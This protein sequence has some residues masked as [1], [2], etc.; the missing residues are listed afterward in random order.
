LPPEGRD[1]ELSRSLADIHSR[2]KKLAEWRA[3]EETVLLN[4]PSTQL[5]A[6]R[7]QLRERFPGAHRGSGNVDGAPENVLPGIPCLDTVGGVPKGC[8]LEIVAREAGS[9]LLAA[10]LRRSRELGQPTV[11]IDGM[12]SFDPVT[13]GPEIARD[14]LWLRCREVGEAVK[15]ADF[16]LRDGNLPV[17]ILDLQLTP[18]RELDSITSPMWYRLRNLAEQTRVT[19]LVLANRRLAPCAAPRLEL[20]AGVTLE[21]LDV[22]RLELEARMEMRV[23]RDQRGR[24]G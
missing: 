18:A 5:D 1:Y 9:L 21:S 19:L 12:D 6:L 23:L 7:A 2:L 24:N 13:T 3:F 8:I 16:L 22:P 4:S 11:L 20:T 15:A 17:V 14:L 10:V